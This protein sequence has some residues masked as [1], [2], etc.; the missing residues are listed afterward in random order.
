MIW[1]I[2]GRF[3]KFLDSLKRFSMAESFRMVL[4]M[5]AW[6]VCAWSLKFP[7]GLRVWKESELSGKFLNTVESC[8]I[9]WKITWRLGKFPDCPVSG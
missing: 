7:D 5:C 4:K 3:G 8:W 9:N 6:K 2:A 1:K